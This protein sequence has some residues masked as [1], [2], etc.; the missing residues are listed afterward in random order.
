V[1]LTRMKGSFWRTCGYCCDTLNYLHP[2]EA[3]LLLERA[4]L[5]VMDKDQEDGQRIPLKTFYSMVVDCV[6]I[7]S[8][9]TYVKLKARLR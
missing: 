8:Y 5:L 2:E 4:Y 1:H 3:L 9:L 6:D 7:H